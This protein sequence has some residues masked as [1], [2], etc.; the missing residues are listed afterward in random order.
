MSLEDLDIIKIIRECRRSGVQKLKIGEMEI[1]FEIK[2]E[3]IS[4]KEVPVES[5]NEEAMIQ[6]AEEAQEEE[7]FSVT[8]EMISEWEIHNPQEIDKQILLGNLSQTADGQV[9][10]VK[11]SNPTA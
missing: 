4:R 8:D 2:P 1:T 10:P 3:R 7:G 11:K 6:V 5:I 9:F